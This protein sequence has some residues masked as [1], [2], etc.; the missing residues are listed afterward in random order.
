MALLLRPWQSRRDMDRGKCRSR[1]GCNINTYG[2][3]IEQPCRD[4]GRGN[5]KGCRCIGRAPEIWTDADA[6]AEAGA[7]SVLD[8][9]GMEFDAE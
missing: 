5:G 3:H 1:G 9:D 4:R 8:W 7:K 2:V 6:E